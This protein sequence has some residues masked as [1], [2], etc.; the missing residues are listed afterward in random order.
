VCVYTY[1]HY[2]DQYL[3]IFDNG[4]E[5]E[6][7]EFAQAVV[8]GYARLIERVVHFTLRVY[9][10]YPAV[11][12]CVCVVE[13]ERERERESVCVSKLMNIRVYVHIYICIYVCVCVCVRVCVCVCD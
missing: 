10:H 2:I 11:C 9:D 6:I 3:A 13:R 4:G 5:H 1:I 8:R 7:Y 12:V